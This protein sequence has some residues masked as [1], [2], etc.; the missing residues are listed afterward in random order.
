MTH[1][2]SD[3]FKIISGTSN[4]QL[5]Q[6]IAK[7]LGVSLSGTHIQRFSDGELNIRIEEPVRGDDIFLIQSTSKPVNEH[8]ME[9][10]IM[11]DALK[12][13]SAGR[14]TAVI[15]YFGYA[16]QDR[17]VKSREPITAKLVADIITA[18]GADR[19]LTMDLH[20]AQIQG[21]FNIPLDHLFG[22][23][24]FYRHFKNIVDGNNDKFVVVSPDFGSVTRARE[25]AEKL[26][27]SIA[28]VHKRRS[29]PNQSHVVNVI[30]EVEGK[31][32]ILI[33]DLI[34]TAGTFVNAANS[35]IQHGAVEVLGAVTHPVLSGNAIRLIEESPIKELTVL[36]TINTNNICKNSKIKIIS[37][38]NVFAQA[39]E[40][41]NRHQ[42]IS[43]LAH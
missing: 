33:D 39:I 20:A 4:P 29:K 13:A 15:P 41:I 21:F 1:S 11:I 14:I 43:E 27:V 25:L 22:I 10:L 6:D 34:D 18:A 19:I 32:A 42:S 35:I 30:G 2:L 36:D 37:V 3:E 31:T 12:R 26:N 38:A 23:P 16:R 8:L 24:I 5:A 17:K 40:R 7:I 9:L 28:I